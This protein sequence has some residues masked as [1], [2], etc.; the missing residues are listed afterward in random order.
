MKPQSSE[1]QKLRFILIIFLAVKPFLH[2]WGAV[3][4][5][6]IPRTFILSLEE[7][8]MCLAKECRLYLNMGNSITTFFKLKKFWIPKLI[9]SPGFWMKECRP[10]L[11][12]KTYTVQWRGDKEVIMA[13]RVETAWPF[14]NGAMY[15]LENP[16]DSIETALDH[17]GGGWTQ[18]EQ[19]RWKAR[20]LP[21]SETN[22]TIRI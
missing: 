12:S 9:W 2:V 14:A 15:S 10:A 22:L 19:T 5:L 13:G 17:K 21:A 3:Q 20:P 6:L 11:F 18:S 7:V 8:L 16:W 1:N 4:P